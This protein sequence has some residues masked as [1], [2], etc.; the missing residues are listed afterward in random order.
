M[1]NHRA[2]TAMSG[3]RPAEMIS[4]NRESTWRMF[5]LRFEI[6]RI[7]S[8]LLRWSVPTAGRRL[9][10]PFKTCYKLIP[11]ETDG[12][13]RR[14]HEG[15]RA[16]V[17]SRVDSGSDAHAVLQFGCRPEQLF[18]QLVRVPAQC[19]P[20]RSIP[21]RYSALGRDEPRRCRQPDR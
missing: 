9:D 4:A 15:S 17:S 14:F 16:L 8:K 3:G 21:R 19:I 11:F 10:A 13:Q 2:R 20:C 6:L 7:I 18:E 5:P 12:S 1:A